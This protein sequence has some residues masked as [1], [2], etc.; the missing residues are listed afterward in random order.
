MNRAEDN[1]TVLPTQG[2][3][4]LLHVCCGPCAEYPLLALR[5]SGYQVSG[6]FYNPNIHPLEEFQARLD[7]ARRFA[8]L[9]NFE[10][11]KLGTS[12]PE[13][14]LKLQGQAQAVHCRFCMGIRMSKVAAWAA[15]HGYKYFTSSLLVSPWQ[16]RELI[17]QQ[18]KSAAERYGLVFLDT[19]FRD[20]YRQGQEMAKAD[21]LYRQK[22]CAC[23]YSLHE[24]NPKY[25]R[26]YCAKF[27]IAESELPQRER[28]QLT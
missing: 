11:A 17:I 26:R 20:G 9:H 28:S 12:E 21:G 23:L 19:D 22:Y 7:S 16:A 2:E 6:L 3:K 1:G 24:T 15:K 14:W 8:D 10:M 13:R 18:G 4:L 25:R 5:E 27:G